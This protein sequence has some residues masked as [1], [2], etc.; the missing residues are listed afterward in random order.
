MPWSALQ[1]I[2]LRFKFQQPRL[3]QLDGHDQLLHLHENWT[4]RL[5]R[6]I[7]DMC[8]AR[9]CFLPC[10][11]FGMSL[12]FDFVFSCRVLYLVVVFCFFVLPFCLG[13]A[14]CSSFSALFAASVC[15]FTPFFFPSFFCFCGFLGLV[16]LF[17]SL[18]S[19]G[20]LRTV[21]LFWPFLTASFRSLLVV[22]CLHGVKSL[23]W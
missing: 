13:S 7:L 8:S 20:H 18:F 14:F 12:K 11:P 15:D 5:Q 19:L 23:T 21:D 4:Q 22:W 2:S 6:L 3:R 17:C 10:F 9:T 1:S 16:S